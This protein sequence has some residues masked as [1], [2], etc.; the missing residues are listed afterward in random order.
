[1]SAIFERQSKI[2]RRMLLTKPLYW[3][4]EKE[5]RM[6]QMTREIEEKAVITYPIE[7]LK[8]IIFGERV[9]AVGK[10]AILD[11]LRAKHVANPLRTDFELSR[12]RL[13]PD[14][15]LDRIPDATLIGWLDE[16]RFS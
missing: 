14:G 6:F 5:V 11:V 3:E 7:A 12:A 9:S 10:K 1:M 2:S 15:S 13:K 16:N 4:A 8:G